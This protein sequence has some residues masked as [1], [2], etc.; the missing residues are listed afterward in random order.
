[1]KAIGAY[2]SSNL[3]QATQPLIADFVFLLLEKSDGNMRIIFHLNQKKA[4]G[5]K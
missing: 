3:I 4:L 2:I 5:L 1:M